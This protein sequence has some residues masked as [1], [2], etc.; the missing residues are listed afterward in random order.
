MLAP[1]GEAVPSVEIAAKMAKALN[2]SLDYLTGI[3]DH[4][5]DQGILDYVQ[6]IQQLPDEDREHILYTINSLI[7][8]TK[9]KQ[10]K[11]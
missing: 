1:A 8:H 9:S 10:T 6:T 4:Q 3:T 5:I 2:V 7:Q 11:K